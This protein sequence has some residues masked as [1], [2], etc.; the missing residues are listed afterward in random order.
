AY[1]QLDVKHEPLTLIVPHFEQPLPPLQPSAS[2][3]FSNYSYTYLY[4]FPAIFRVPGPPD[5]ELFDLQ[6]EFSTERD[7]LVQASQK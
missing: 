5:L 4:V 2:G 1:A 7:R 3:H 6:E